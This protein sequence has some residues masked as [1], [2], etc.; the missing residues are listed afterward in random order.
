VIRIRIEGLKGDLLAAI[1]TQVIALAGGEL[2]AGAA[3]S[4]AKNRIRVRS[5]PL[6]P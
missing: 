1:L 5:L 2:A 3:V 4:V 6:G